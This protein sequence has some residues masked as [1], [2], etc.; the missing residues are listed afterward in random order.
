MSTVRVAAII[1]V[2]MGSTRFPGKAIAADTGRALVLHVADAA[3]RASRIN[4]VVVAS[5]DEA[6]ATVVTDAGVPHVMTSTTHPNGSCRVAQAASSIEA[7]IIVNLQGDEPELEPALIDLCV[8]TLISDPQAAAA[9]LAAPLND[10]AQALDP[11]IVKV[12]LDAGGRALY[13]SRLPIPASRDD[14]PIERLRH[15]GIYAYRRSVLEQYPTLPP[16]PLEEAEHLE[17]L[18][19][20]AHRLPIA[21]ACCDANHAGIDTPEQYEAFVN[22]WRRCHPD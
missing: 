4:Q 17:Q 22:R 13:F 8:E 21:V 9:T 20:L 15:V 16:S 6:I 12:V 11:N 5:D 19:L 18:R 3:S 2:R 1:P 10:P 7:D 14:E